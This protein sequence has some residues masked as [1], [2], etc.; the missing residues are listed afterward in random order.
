VIINDSKSVTFTSNEIRDVLAKHLKVRGV[1]KMSAGSTPK[2][3]YTDDPSKFITI[4][5]EN[6]ENL[7]LMFEGAKNED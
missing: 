3:T 6:S 4:T 2:L 1:L 5:F 7:S